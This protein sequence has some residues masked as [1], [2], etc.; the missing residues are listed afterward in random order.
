MW[1]VARVTCLVFHNSSG[2]TLWDF[3]PIQSVY[4]IFLITLTCLI[5]S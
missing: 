3:V 5:K 1:C 2:H 4:L